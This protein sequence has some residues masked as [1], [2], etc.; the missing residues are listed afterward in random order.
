LG[1]TIVKD[2][3]ADLGGKVQ[4]IPH[5]ELGGAEFIVELPLVGG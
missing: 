5:G 4:A 2:C 3:V 1:L